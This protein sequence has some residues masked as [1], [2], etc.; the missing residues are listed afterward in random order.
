MFHEQQQTSQESPEKWVKEIM[1]D[2]VDRA[3][4]G[5][6][7]SAAQS[8]H[9]VELLVDLN[10]QYASHV[11]GAMCLQRA[12]AKRMPVQERKVLFNRSE[13]IWQQAV[14]QWW[15]GDDLSSSTLKSALGL[16]C[17]DSMRSIIIDRRLPEIESN[18]TL[19]ENIGKIA[20]RTVDAHQ[21]FNMAGRNREAQYVAGF[22][23]ELVVMMLHQRFM[24]EDMQSN[25]ML[26]VPATLFQDTGQKSAE[27]VP[28]NSWDVTIYSN[29]RKGPLRMVY[30]VQVKTQRTMHNMYDYAP[31]ITVVSVMDDL[32]LGENER[33]GTPNVTSILRDLVLSAN[34]S[35][36]LAVD[37]ELDARQRLLIDVLD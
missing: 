27:N 22:E 2:F 21:E 25:S 14:D 30:K 3:R 18:Q 11:A 33:Y 32:S 34:A 16:V 23:A 10:D 15:N 19:Y 28:N 9:V 13:E 31:Q 26:A 35:D 12:T 37:D 8:D 17:M 7:Y 1:Y 6:P 4:E 20:T 36:R 5:R 24:I 29:A